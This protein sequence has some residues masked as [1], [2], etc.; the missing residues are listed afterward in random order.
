[1][2]EGAKPKK[3]F[4]FRD[5]KILD[6]LL[7]KNIFRFS[8]LKFFFVIIFVFYECIL[9]LMIY[10]NFNKKIFKYFLIQFDV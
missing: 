3:K 5:E 2:R 8:T 4:K 1:M 9:G 7:F 6:G 10:V